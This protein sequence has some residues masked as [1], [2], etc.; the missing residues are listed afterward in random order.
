MSAGITYGSP[1][2]KSPTRTLRWIGS[3]LSSSNSVAR[4]RERFGDSIKRTDGR[5]GLHVFLLIA[6]GAYAWNTAP[7]REDPSF[8]VRDAWIVTIWP[9]A[10]AE[11]VERLV[12]DPDCVPPIVGARVVPHQLISGIPVKTP[13]AIR[14]LGPRLGSEQGWPLRMRNRTAG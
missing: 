14:V 5:V 2:R 9:G 13:I 7:R 3:G 10:T 11:E 6:Y 4:A 8:N 12:A 1:L